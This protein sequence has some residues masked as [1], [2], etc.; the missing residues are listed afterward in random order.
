MPVPVDDTSAIEARSENGVR[1]GTGGYRTIEAF[2]SMV[3]WAM[4]L[5][6]LSTSRV[7]LS[8]RTR[9]C[10]CQ[11]LPLLCLTNR[12]GKVIVDRRPKRMPSKV[13]MPVNKSHASC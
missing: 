12:D 13:E 10:C 5:L 6:E 7:P 8:H 1:T 3:G 2:P 4:S 9:V 11:Y